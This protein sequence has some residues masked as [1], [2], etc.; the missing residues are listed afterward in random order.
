MHLLLRK[1]EVSGGKHVKLPFTCVNLLFFFFDATSVYF[2]LDAWQHNLL[3][4]CPFCQCLLPFFL[5][6]ERGLQWPSGQSHMLRKAGKRKGK[7]LRTQWS[8]Q[9]SS[10][11]ISMRETRCPLVYTTVC[12]QKPSAAP[13]DLPLQDLLWRPVEKRIA[14]V[15]VPDKGNS[16]R[17]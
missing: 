7:L 15:Q 3:S 1:W 5:L 4:V 12:S 6:L 10:I 11:L 2:G 9:P 13:A 16:S 8:V 17:N 14:G